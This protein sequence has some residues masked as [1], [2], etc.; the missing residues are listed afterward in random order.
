MRSRTLQIIGEMVHADSPLTIDRLAS[1]I[2]EAKC[3]VPPSQLLAHRVAAKTGMRV[4][5]SLYLSIMPDS[6]E[7]TVLGWNNLV[8]L[9]ADHAYRTLV[10][11]SQDTDSK[12]EAERVLRQADEYHSEYEDYEALLN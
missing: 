5:Q 9:H 3:H 2:D 12:Q 1:I 4:Y 10:H 8:T 6:W 7:Y 11:V